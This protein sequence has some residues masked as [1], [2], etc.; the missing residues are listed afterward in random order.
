MLH[1]QILSPEQVDLLPLVNKFSADYYLVGGT[2][3]ALQIGHRRSIDFDLFS[4][5]PIDRNVIKRTID[6]LKL[7]LDVIFEDADQLTGVVNKVKITWYEYPYA[8]KPTVDFDDIMK[9]PDLL[10]LSAMKAF[11]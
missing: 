11:A 9:M 8:T 3:V 6:E 1:K 10:T 7:S 2:A 4:D 5:K